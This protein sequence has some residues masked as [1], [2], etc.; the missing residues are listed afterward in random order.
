MNNMRNPVIYA[1]LKR[2]HPRD[3]AH[4]RNRTNQHSLHFNV[5]PK[6]PNPPNAWTGIG[7]L[8]LAVF[9]LH[10]TSAVFLAFVAGRCGGSFVTETFAEVL[11]TRHPWGYPVLTEGACRDPRNVSCFFGIPE[12][13]DVA[14]RGLEWNVFTL[15]A[16]FEWISASFALG[17][18]SGNFNPAKRPT[19]NDVS[20]IKLLSLV[21]NLAGALW[22]LIPGNVSLLQAGITI[23][24]LVIA[25]SVQYYP[26]GSEDGSAIVMHYTEYCSSASLL[27]VAVLILYAPHPQSWAVIIGFTGILLCNLTGVGAHL[28]KIDTVHSSHSSTWTGPRRRITSSSTSFT[29]GWGCSWGC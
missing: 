29:L 28:C 26:M 22:L 13:Y 8:R 15:I 21:W 23:L 9:I 10:S 24:A 20:Q 5:Q 17:H 14:Q 18:L 3:A 16:A 6:L 12:A 7:V 1:Q 11:A 19:G 27:F 2:Q 4:T 25:T